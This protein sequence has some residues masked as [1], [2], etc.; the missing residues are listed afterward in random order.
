[1]GKES[2]TIQDLLN[3]VKSLA[4]VLA[5]AGIGF[6]DYISQL[7]YLLFLKMD[8]EKVKTFDDESTIP[9]GYRWS[10]LTS[11]DGEELMKHYNETLEKLS[12]QDNLIGTIF[13]KAQ[14][15]FDQPVYLLK[16]IQMIDKE[17]WLLMSD[18]VKGAIYESI[19]EQNGQDAKSG[20]GQYF[21]PRPVIKAM[22][23]CINPKIGETVCDPACGTGGFL[24]M[25]F[26]HM[27]VQSNDRDKIDFLRNKALH[28]NDITPLVVTLASMNLY[29]HG[30]GTNQSP[31]V[32]EDS[33]LKEPDTLYDVILANP[34]FGVRAAGSVDVQRNDF[35][36]ETK[37]NQLNFLQHIMNLVKNG[38][39]VGIV[40]PDTVLSIGEGKEIRRRL[41][42][43]FNLHTILRL[44]VGIFY[45]NVR[46][47]VLF[48]TK[49]VPTKEIW[50]YD[51][52]ER[53][54]HSR[55]KNKLERQ[56]LDDFVKC[57]NHGELLKREETYNAESNPDGRWRKYSIEEIRE[58]DELNL[59]LKWMNSSESE[60]PYSLEELLSDFEEK[61]KDISN[62]LAELRKELANILDK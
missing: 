32:C 39:R 22:V 41:L 33:L 6:T 35:Y 27:K 11:L 56:H 19:L 13:T 4:N 24:L 9:E 16:A 29:L 61:N 34:P 58:N 17:N 59:D 37:N 18:D 25:A 10:D 55:V 28:G 50:Y 38:G 1:M 51:Y 3:K 52:R 42:E 31:I 46:T 30:I 23:E 5:G 44:P 21:T 2:T 12:K 60:C 49:G 15:K 57:Y 47:V 20:A 8:D 43:D 53:V 45:K 7:T 62:C 14:N 48:F 40:L 36:K 26:E 54:K